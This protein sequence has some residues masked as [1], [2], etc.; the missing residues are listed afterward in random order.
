MLNVLVGACVVAI[1]FL[2]PSRE[3]EL[4]H[5][6]RDC[7]RSDPTGYYITYALGKS[8]VGE[9]HRSI[10]RPIPYI[11]AKA[12]QLLQRLGS[13]IATEIA[14]DRKIAD[15]LFL[16]PTDLSDHC[17]VADTSLLNERL[18]IFCDFVGLRP[19][20]LGR[21]WYIRIHQMRKWFLLLLFWSGK[22][23]VL[24]AARWIAGHSDVSQVY[25][26]LVTEFPEENLA[27]LEADYAIE[28]LRALDAIK[29]TQQGETGLNALYET[30]LGHFQVRSLSL[31]DESEW[32]DYV[33][34]L[35]TNEGFHI[36]PHSVRAKHGSEVI[37]MN[38]SFVLR[39]IYGE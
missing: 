27:T 30:V 13:S 35:R 36:E 39:E 26:Y 22:F 12:I 1:G 3:A 20:R 17:R 32:M 4:T 8:N 21:R 25:A 23:D 24:D 11:S 9:T 14:V 18:D 37:G 6:K 33:A 5:L 10:E 34:L 29:E 38:I 15:N 19:D 2:K 28:R 31:V 16:L 7:L